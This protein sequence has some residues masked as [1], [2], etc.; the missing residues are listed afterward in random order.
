MTAQGKSSNESRLRGDFE[1][2]M[3]KYRSA[4][5]CLLSLVLVTGMT[6]ASAEVP[7]LAEEAESALKKAVQY[8]R[9]TISTNGGYLWTYSEDLSERAGEGKA[10]ETQI[11][12][13]PPGTPSVGSTYLRAYEATGDDVY[14]EAAKAAADAL[15]WGQLESG[16][17]DYKVDF[18]PEGSQRWYYRRDKGKV[19][20][21]R[22]RNYSVFDD[23]NSQSAL[24]FIMAVHKTTGEGKYLSA[25]EYGLAFMLRSQFENGAWPQVYPLPSKGYSRWYTFNDNAIN[26]CI[27]VMLDAYHIYGDEKYLESA[28]R[29]GDF[30]IASQLPEPQAGWAQ[31]YDYDMK[32]APARRFEPAAVN[33]AVT[34][35]NIRTLIDLYLETGEEKYLKPI[36]AAIDWL[37]KSRMEN[38]KWARFYE[39][40]TNKPVYVNTDREV[41]YEF[42]NIQPGYSWTGNYASSAIRLYE[43]VKSMGRENY[44]A[45]RDAPSTDESRRR[46]L[47]SLEPRVRDVI[48]KQDAQGRW[49]DDGE[50][51]CSTFIRNVRL[52]SDCIALA[53]SMN[54]TTD[55]HR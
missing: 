53:R 14:L 21:E 37:E 45:E 24:R 35:R 18:D 22:R 33:G 6:S 40:G 43:K 48:A 44:L 36:P 38:D 47:A 1:T 30:I 49:A 4:L 17:W 39:L 29:G 31:Q 10:T 7:T 9:W 32:P 55:E 52:L 41:V 2:M 12:V 34:P 3:R 46:R 50:I 16:G 26:D 8:F 23:N 27:N 19:D 28:K 25:V 42:V 20:P 51:R 13:Q 5:F 54:E 11:W 15:V